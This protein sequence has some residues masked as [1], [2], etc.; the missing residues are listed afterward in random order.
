MQG[1]RRREMEGERK[2]KTERDRGRGERKDREKQRER[3]R[4]SRK[5]GGRE[6]GK[7]GERDGGLRLEFV[8]QYQRETSADWSLHI[9]PHIVI[10]PNILQRVLHLYEFSPRA[11]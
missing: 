7:D 9:R 10:L 5:D 2:G 4:D 6:E 8:N 11:E 3:G 1:E